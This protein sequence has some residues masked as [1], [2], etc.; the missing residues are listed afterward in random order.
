MIQDVI[1]CV[2]YSPGLPDLRFLLDDHPVA[3]C[4]IVVGEGGGGV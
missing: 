4:K 1:G 3:R 2:V